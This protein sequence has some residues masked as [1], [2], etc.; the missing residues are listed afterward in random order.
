MS[1]EID[2]NKRLQALLKYQVLDTPPEPEYDQLAKLASIIC[3]T[4][5]SIISFVDDKRQWFKSVYG[6]NATETEKEVSFCQHAIKTYNIFEVNDASK[7][8]L[9]KDNP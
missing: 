8:E 6:F 7:H 4:P 9:F 3:Q 2:E 5:I 1:I